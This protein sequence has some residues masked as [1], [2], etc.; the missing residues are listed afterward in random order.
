MSAGLVH[1]MERNVRSGPI[2]LLRALLMRWAVPMSIN[3]GTSSATGRIRR[4]RWASTT[5]D[6][7][8]IV[9]SICPR[10]TVSRSVPSRTQGTL[11][12]IWRHHSARGNNLRVTPCSFSRHHQ[13][14]VVYGAALGDDGSAPTIWHTATTEYILIAVFHFTAAGC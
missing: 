5:V 7:W 13:F 12:I 2:L 10:G 11:R 14:F 8:T 9:D 3:G 1:S 6:S 4:K